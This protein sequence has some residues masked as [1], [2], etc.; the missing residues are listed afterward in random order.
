[1]RDLDDGIGELCAGQVPSFPCDGLLGWTGAGVIERLGGWSA[2]VCLSLRGFGA[3]G[4][5]PEK[6]RFCSGS[7]IL[8]GDVG[9]DDLAEGGSCRLQ[10]RRDYPQWFH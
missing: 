8:G 2:F 5:P 7:C 6:L 3:R 1:M 10:R 9:R 4:V